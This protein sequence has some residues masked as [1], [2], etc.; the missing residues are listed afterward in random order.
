MEKTKS[1]TGRQL[2][3]IRLRGRTGLNYSVAVTLDLLNIQRVNHCT[4][5]QDTPEVVGMIKKAKDYITW[6]PIDDDTLKALVE[7]RGEAVAVAQFRSERN[8]QSDTVRFASATKTLK[9]GKVG[10]FCTQ[11]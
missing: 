2:A 3:V 8:V 9:Y 4:I 1:G 10:R 11:P 5:V 7:K 6:G